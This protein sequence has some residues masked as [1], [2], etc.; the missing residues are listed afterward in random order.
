[1]SALVPLQM[2]KSEGGTKVQILVL[3]CM[4]RQQLTFTIYYETFILFFLHIFIV[5]NTC[6]TCLLYNLY[7][8]YTILVLTFNVYQIKGFSAGE[9]KVK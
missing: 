9:I 1:M 4:Q 3:C 6:N 5:L 2:C 8:M 7:N